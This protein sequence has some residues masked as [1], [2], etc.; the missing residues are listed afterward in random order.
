MPG[1]QAEFFPPPVQGRPRQDR[2]G[3]KVDAVGGKI[4]GGIEAGAETGIIV[5]GQAVDQ[6]EAEG[7]PLGIQKMD[8]AAKS[9]GS[10][11]RCR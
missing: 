6:I 5:P 3:K 1:P 8:L 11:L 7:Y 4:Q 2:Q 9:S 10:R